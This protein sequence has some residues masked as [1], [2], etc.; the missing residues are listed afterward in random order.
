MK[1]PLVRIRLDGNGRIYR[2]GETLSGEYRLEGIASQD[3]RAVE[4]S[5]LWHTE[6]KG[7]EDLAVHDFRRLSVENGDQIDLLRPGRFS[8]VLPNSPLSYRGVLVKI[9]WCVRVR[10][11]LTRGREVLGEVPFR[12][13]EVLPPRSATFW[14]RAGRATGSSRRSPGRRPQ[15]SRGHPPAKAPKRPDQNRPL[16]QGTAT[17]LATT[18]LSPRLRR[19]CREP[20]RRSLGQV[21]SLLDALYA[22][23]RH[24]VPLSARDERR[25]VGRAALPERVAGPDPR[26]PRKR[27]ISPG[28]RLDSD[29]RKGG[30]AGR[31]HRTA[32]PTAPIA[33]ELDPAGRTQPAHRG[34]RRWL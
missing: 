2:P 3:I 11:F 13:G 10:V 23:R 20:G 8:T 6:G 5:V 18:A 24:P 30:P 28:G 34:D 31:A 25:I 29:H 9:R 32:R 22:A 15:A 27:Q 19:P 21:Q 7:D 26:L 12:L 4:V 33:A 14:A 1:E 16:P 17:R